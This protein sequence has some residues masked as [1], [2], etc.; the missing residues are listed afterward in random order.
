MLEI[1]E[2][3]ENY[4]SGGL[5]LRPAPGTDSAEAP[6]T[7]GV[8]RV[9]SRPPGSHHWKRRAGG[10]EGLRTT[11]SGPGV[12]A[13]SQLRFA[14]EAEAERGQTGRRCRTV[15]GAFTS[16]TTNAKDEGDDGGRPI[17][18]ALCTLPFHLI[19]S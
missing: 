14:P 19:Y 11:P 13:C 6:L 3:G 12:R 7:Q 9:G 18:T 5:G 4:I 16:L 8:S 17:H 2:M 15:R 10:A 1:L